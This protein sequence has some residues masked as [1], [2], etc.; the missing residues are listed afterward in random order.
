M[1]LDIKSLIIPFIIG[2]FTVAG[3]KFA[4]KNISNTAIAALIGAIPIGL[5]SIVFISNDKSLGYSENYFFITLA[6]LTSIAFF[7]T[8]RTYTNWNK[9][10][11]LVLAL[12]LWGVIATIR[13]IYNQHEIK[14]E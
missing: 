6:L 10:L 11:I 14:K 5:I 12:I 13:I 1:K 2:G 8:L 4:S 3:V 9:N 7:Y